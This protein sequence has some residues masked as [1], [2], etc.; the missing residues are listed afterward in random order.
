MQ[1]F[2][3]V[4]GGIKAVVWTDL[5][6]T[7]VMFVGLILLLVFGSQKVGGIEHVWEIASQGQRLNV[8]E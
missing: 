7:I 3:F 6:Q 8:L 2:C 4:Q 1:I 5:I